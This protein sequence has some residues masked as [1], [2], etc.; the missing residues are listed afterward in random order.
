[1]ATV[2]R[3]DNVIVL[4]GVENDDEALNRVSIYNV[5]TQKSHMLPPM[6][7]KRKDCTAVVLG[8][9]IIVMGGLDENNHVLK[10]VESFN[11]SRYTWEELPSMHEARAFATSVAC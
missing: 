2:R 3:H 9:M 7:Y 11:F 10:S 1:M 4:G 8:S 5:K 6:L